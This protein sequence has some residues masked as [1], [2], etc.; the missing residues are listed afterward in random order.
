[1][2]LTPKALRELV[3]YCPLTGQFWSKVSSTHR[4]LFTSVDSHGYRVATIKGHRINAQRAAFALMHDRWPLAVQFR[5]G[6]KTDCRESN[7]KEGWRGL[8]LIK[9]ETARHEDDGP[10]KNQ[11]K[12]SCETEPL[13][14]LTCEPDYSNNR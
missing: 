12:N 8:R 6:D 9:T 14:G 1:M 3:G 13:G 11:G 5:N 7:L 10:S 2:R 4:P